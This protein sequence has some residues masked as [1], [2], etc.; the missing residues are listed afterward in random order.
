M[1]ILLVL[2][3]LLSGSL[4]AQND[5]VYV[6]IDYKGHEYEY[7]FISQDIADQYLDET[8]DTTHSSYKDDRVLLIDYM[9]KISN[10]FEGH[11]VRKEGKNKHKVWTIKSTYGKKLRKE[12]KAKKEKLEGNNP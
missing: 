7:F 3:F 6:F 9:E 1:K 12:K 2:L 4:Y 5:S 10:K 8:F 11:M